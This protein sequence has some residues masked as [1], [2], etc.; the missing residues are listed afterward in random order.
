MDLPKTSKDFSPIEL[1]LQ[2]LFRPLITSKSFSWS[3]ANP[4]VNCIL[5]Y[6]NTCKDD[7]KI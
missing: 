3:K 6:K 7:V 5:G 1:E 2:R 4:Y